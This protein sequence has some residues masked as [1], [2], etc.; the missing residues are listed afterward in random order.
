MLCRLESLFARKVYSLRLLVIVEEIS[1]RF[2][3]FEVAGNKH[4]LGIVNLDENL[5]ELL[6]VLRITVGLDG[7]VVVAYDRRNEKVVADSSVKLQV[8]VR[9]HNHILAVAEAHATRNAS[10]ARKFG[11]REEI[12]VVFLGKNEVVARAFV[13]VVGKHILAAVEFLC[14]LRE[15]HGEGLEADFC[16]C[17][18][19]LV[20][21]NGRGLEIEMVFCVNR[22]SVG[23]DEFYGTLHHAHRVEHQRV[24]LH[25]QIFE[26]Y[27]RLCRQ[28]QCWQRGKHKNYARQANPQS[29]KPFVAVAVA[30][31]HPNCK[32]NKTANLSIYVIRNGKLLDLTFYT[33]IS[34]VAV[35]ACHVFINTY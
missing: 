8:E 3:L 10:L 17:W 7:D 20:K 5:V 35:I 13:L 9:V 19:F 27:Q 23:I 33:D 34:E 6:Q 26:A 24:A 18:R 21:H 2:L 32:Y 1:L 22:I 30:K 25:R 16:P 4:K 11:L 15:I 31:I 28:I 12:I 29:G 14:W